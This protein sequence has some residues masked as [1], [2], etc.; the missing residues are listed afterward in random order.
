MVCPTCAFCTAGASLPP[1]DGILANQTGP[2]A[3]PTQGDPTPPGAPT[4]NKLPGG[5]GRHQACRMAWTAPRA[6]RHRVPPVAGEREMLE[7]WLDFHR[8]TLL[9]KCAGLTEEH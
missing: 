4:G 6:D 2:R 8:Q 1:R 3:S 9:G 5:P 7:A